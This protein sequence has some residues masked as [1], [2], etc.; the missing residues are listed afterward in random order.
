MW[1]AAGT[2]LD[3]SPARGRLVLATTASAGPRAAGSGCP[4]PARS[5][6][7]VSITASTTG[8]H[9]VTVRMTDGHGDQLPP[10]MIELAV[11]P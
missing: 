3:V 6:Q 10:V 11:T 7:D 4:A 1:S 5:S 2:G 8:P 9:L